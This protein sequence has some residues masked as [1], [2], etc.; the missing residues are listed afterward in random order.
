MAFTFNAYP[1]L[2]PEQTSPLGNLLSNSVKK[3][4]ML[5]QAQY[6]EPMLKQALQESILKNKDYGPNMESQMG[7][8][9]A[10][11]GHLGSLTTGQNITNKYLPESLL[12]EIEGKKALAN[13]RKITMDLLAQILGGNSQAQG[14]VNT[15]RFENSLPPESNNQYQQGSG[16][17]LFAEQQNQTQQPT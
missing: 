5:N 9:G 17:P 6:Q 4:M 1:I 14:N 13:K 11:A 3:Y 12:A 15:D 7:L 2:T 16:M 8:R 10:Q